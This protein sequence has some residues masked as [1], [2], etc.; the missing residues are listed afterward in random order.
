MRQKERVSYIVNIIPNPNP[1]KSHPSKKEKRKKENQ[2]KKKN[3][4]KKG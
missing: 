3:N 4:D 2:Q 1:H